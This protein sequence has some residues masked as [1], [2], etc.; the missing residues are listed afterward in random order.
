MAIIG[1]SIKQGRQAGGGGVQIV[2][3]LIGGNPVGLA[4]GGVVAGG[5]VL[6]AVQAG[7]GAVTCEFFF[8]TF[9][10]K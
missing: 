5:G 7:G 1:R 2:A 4:A 6:G 8:P 9:L 3:N 10:Q